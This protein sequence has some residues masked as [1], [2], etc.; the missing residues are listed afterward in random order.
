MKW[1]IAFITAV[2]ISALS[3]FGIFFFNSF[4][5]KQINIWS[6]SHFMLG[7]FPRFAVGLHHI[8]TR[9]I[10]LVIPLVVIASFIGCFII[11]IKKQ[12]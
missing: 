9:N 2:V 6:K 10:F 8:L 5:A 7:V 3:I 4:M 1:F 11:A 12:N